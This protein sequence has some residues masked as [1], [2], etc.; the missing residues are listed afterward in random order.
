[1][2]VEAGIKGRLSNH[3]VAEGQTRAP[4]R[5]GSYGARWIVSLNPAGLAIVVGDTRIVTTVGRPSD[6]NLICARCSD[7]KTEWRIGTTNPTSGE[8][9]KSARQFGQTFSGALTCS[10]GMFEKLRY[11]DG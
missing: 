6:V 2:D 8:R 5:S 1:M 9:T 4:G 10:G 11:A 7:R 3:H